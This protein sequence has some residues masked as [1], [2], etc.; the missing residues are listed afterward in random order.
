M[1]MKKF[2]AV[3]E[4]IRKKKKG[5]QSFHV[6]RSGKKSSSPK[7]ILKEGYSGTKVVHSAQNHKPTLFK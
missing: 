3:Q 5:S 4:E 1:E 7:T 6:D 2:Q